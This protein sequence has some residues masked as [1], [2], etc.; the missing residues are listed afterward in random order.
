MLSDSADAVAKHNSEIFEFIACESPSI[1]RQAWTVLLN[2][3]CES[4]CVLVMLESSVC[5][6]I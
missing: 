3:S 6:Y 4:D 1:R 5:L 2:L